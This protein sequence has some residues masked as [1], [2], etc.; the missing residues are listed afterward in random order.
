MMSEKVFQEIFDKLQ[1]V[2][3]AD[4]KRIVF[5]AGYTSGSYSMKF[6][7]DCGDGIY[8]D[9][10]SQKDIN[11]AKLIKLFMDIDKILVPI[12]NSLS[13]DSKWSVFTMLVDEKGN[14]KTEFDYTDISENLIAYE[15][16]WKKKYIV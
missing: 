14:M 12:R 5:Y 2:I 4:W 6:Y 3:P 16:E 1:E 11:R 13:D 10:F 7:I 15:Q 9:C 8:V